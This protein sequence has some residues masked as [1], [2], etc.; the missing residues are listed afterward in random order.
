MVHERY[1]ILFLHHV[2]CVENLDANLHAK[3]PLDSRNSP[4]K[5]FFVEDKGVE[6]F[7]FLISADDLSM[8]FSESSDA[9]WTSS[10]L[11]DNE[12]VRFMFEEEE[13]KIEEEEAGD[14]KR[15]PASSF[16]ARDAES[17][18]SESEE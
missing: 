2:N 12:K 14:Q 15:Q 10:F 3:S 9:S 11:S 5:I 6:F 7:S 18:D 16:L 1:H 8:A 4:W 13:K 17:T